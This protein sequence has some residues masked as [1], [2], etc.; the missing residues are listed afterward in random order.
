MYVDRNPLF[1]AFFQLN[2][3]DYEGTLTIH[4]VAGEKDSITALLQQN[5]S[6]ALAAV[7]TSSNGFSPQL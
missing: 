5:T 6:G 3:S 1:T 4:A 2:P 7:S